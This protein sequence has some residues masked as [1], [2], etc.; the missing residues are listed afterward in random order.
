MDELNAYTNGASAG[1]E[2]I[3]NGKWDGGNRDG[4]SGILDFNVYNVGMGM[5]IK[6]NDP[7]YFNNPQFKEFYKKMLESS[8][9]VFNQGKNIPQFQNTN[10]ENI[11][12]NLQNARDAE[13]MRQFLRSNFGNDWT[14]KVYG[15]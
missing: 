10:Q 15:F 7:N 5:A 11:F 4:V 6:E 9:N 1:I 3:K 13:P 14:R 12:Y 2:A 8:M